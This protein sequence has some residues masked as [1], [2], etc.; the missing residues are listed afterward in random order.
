VDFSVRA[1]VLPT[2]GPAVANPTSKSSAIPLDKLVG[3]DQW[4]TLRARI[5]AGSPYTVRRIEFRGNHNF[6]DSTLRRMVVLNEGD[7]FDFGHLR[8]SLSRLSSTGFFKP[9]TKDQVLIQRD[10]AAH[11]LD[12]TLNLEERA[13]GGW[14]L[15][16]SLE[17]PN[18]IRP[19][20]FLVGSRLP[21]WGGEALELSTYF[22]A[23]SL[24]P[25]PQLIPQ[26]LPLA[27]KTRWMPGL[28][29]G[30]P[31]LPAEEWRSGFVLSP[32]LGWQ[33]TL[34]SSGLMRAR[35][36]I[37]ILNDNPVEP[38]KLAVPVWRGP[39]VGGR[40]V[41]SKFAGPLLCEARKS[42]LGW[43]RSAGL[44]ALDLLLALPM[45]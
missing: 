22:A 7:P 18:L 33:G 25:F 45:I 16:G 13:R 32:Q 19:V 31:Y 29:L 4:V 23:V 26:G 27:A 35:G 24:L 20:Q 2:E 39:E 44:A 43:A 34:L 5:D 40:E 36:I 8:R 14:S 41:G 15:S 17:P 3:A 10:P 28:S 1:E 42:R 9:I 37:S 38:P 30:R 6:S 21:D 12:L 11:Q